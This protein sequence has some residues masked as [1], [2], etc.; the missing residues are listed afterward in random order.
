MDEA[1]CGLR[2]GT[3]DDV[4]HAVIRSTWLGA[5]RSG[6]GEQAVMLRRSILGAGTVACMAPKV[7]AQTT[8]KRLGLALSLVLLSR[9]DEV[10]E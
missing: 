3:C 4:Q 10:I 6:N 2:G 5:K 7:A 9:A 1:A 8:A